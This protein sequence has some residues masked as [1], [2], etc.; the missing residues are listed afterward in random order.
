[1]ETKQEPSAVW[2]QTVNSDSSNGTQVHRLIWFVWTA[3][4]ES[5]KL[6]RCKMCNNNNLS[7]LTIDLLHTPTFCQLARVAA[8]SSIHHLLLW[9]RVTHLNKCFLLIKSDVILLQMVQ[10]FCVMYTHV[11]GAFWRWHCGPNSVQWGSGRQRTAA[12]GLYSRWKLLYLG[13]VCRAH[14]GLHTP[15]RWHSG[16]MGSY[17][18]ERYFYL[19]F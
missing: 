16:K 15:C 19:T 7:M 11:A 1:M 13:R 10:S 2:S 14:T 17:S 12:G 8:K 4:A 5:Y 18:E 3:T 6:K 9:K